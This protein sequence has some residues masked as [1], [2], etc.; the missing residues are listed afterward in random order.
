MPYHPTKDEEC[1]CTDNVHGGKLWKCGVN[2]KVCTASMLP[3]TYP[4]CDC[5]VPDFAMSMHNRVSYCR[6]KIPK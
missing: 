4:N 6:K 3:C 1:I 2:S 5:T